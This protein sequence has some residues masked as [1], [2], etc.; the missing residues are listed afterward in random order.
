ELFLNTVCRL[1]TERT[2]LEVFTA[3]L[4]IEHEN[5]R[6][7]PSRF[8]P[9]TLD[10]DLLAYDALCLKLGKAGSSYPAQGIALSFTLCLPHPRMHARKFVLVPLAEIDPLWRHPLLRHTAGELLRR[11]APAQG[12][13]QWHC[14]AADI[15]L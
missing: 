3:L 7:R 12:T 2:V 14:A 8:A 10:L 13:V 4:D 6:T 1:E 5:Q 15:F 9:R 11:F